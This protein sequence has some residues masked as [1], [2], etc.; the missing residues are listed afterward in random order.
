M[1][2]KVFRL[3]LAVILFLGWMGYL[4]FQVVTRPQT[5]AGAPLVVSRPQILASQIDVV[6]NVP[7]ENGE[8]VEITEVLYPGSSALKPGDTIHVTN[9]RDCMPP[10]GEGEKPAR[11]W[12]D[13]GKYLL[14][15]RATG[16]KNTYE[17]APIP[18]SPG[19]Y[20]PRPRI[21]PANEAALAQ[22]KHIAKPE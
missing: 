18:P 6:A 13:P 17:V 19:F 22:Y 2:P 3:I 12:T 8:K 5:A 21:Y 20:Q 1:K 15:L 11:D 16:E 7:D 9:I 10:R 14:P 4:G